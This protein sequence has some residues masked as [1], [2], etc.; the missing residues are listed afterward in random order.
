MQHLCTVLKA[1]I[2]LDVAAGI[3]GIKFAFCLL[4]I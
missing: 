1:K 3:Y 4:A 2:W